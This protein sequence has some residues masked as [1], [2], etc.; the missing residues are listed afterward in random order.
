MRLWHLA[1][2]L[3]LLSSTGAWANDTAPSS[4]AATAKSSPTAPAAEVKQAKPPD[5]YA[6]RAKWGVEVTPGVAIPFKKYLDF[7]SG[8]NTYSMENSPGSGISICLMLNNVEFRWGYAALGA[9]LVQGRIPD[10]IVQQTAAIGLNLN[11]TINVQAT[12]KLIM[13]H[14]SLGYRFTFS[15]VEHL[16]L[17]VPL[18]AGIVIVEPPSFGIVNYSL[19]GFG[20]QTGFVAE[21]TLFDLIALGGSARFSMY[22][23]KPDPNLAGAGLAATE[24]IF[25]NALAWLPMLSLGVHARIYY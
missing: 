22:V 4:K 1:T 6:N 5:K 14:L 17:A 3:Y 16:Q 9:G 15:P 21:Y 20:V 13:H 2:A 11:Q 10:N 18:G 24:K 8:Q 19:M 25:D 12:E 7:G 23:T